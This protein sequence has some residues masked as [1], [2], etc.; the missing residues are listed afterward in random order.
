MIL[1]QQIDDDYIVAFKAGEKL[2]VSVLRMLRSELKTKEIDSR[3]E[4]TESEIIAI[5]RSMIKKRKEAAEAFAAGGSQERADSE[6]E[7]MEI[8]TGY[9]PP[10]LGESE[11]E[12]L[13]A[14]AIDEVGAKGPGD[15][16][17][18]MKMLMPKLMGKADGKTISELVKKMLSS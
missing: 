3:K 9:L 18:V 17:K 2:R 7:E 8:L 15:M 10:D 16:G 14:E 6:K 4:L 12:K 5:V 11:V 13:I 1:R